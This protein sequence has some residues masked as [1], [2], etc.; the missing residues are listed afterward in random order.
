MGEQ[1]EEEQV[2][3]PQAP[4]SGEE[5]FPF[6]EAGPSQGSSPVPHIQTES[7]CSQDGFRLREWECVV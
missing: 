4:I 6:L 2:Q 7:D 3:C 1:G 5:T